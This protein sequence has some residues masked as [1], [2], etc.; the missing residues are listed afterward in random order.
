MPETNYHDAA[1]CEDI[2]DDK[3]SAQTWASSLVSGALSSSEESACNALGTKYETLSSKLAGGGS[4]YQGRVE[5]E[6]L[7]TMSSMKSGCT[8]S[9][10][11]ASIIALNAVIATPDCVKSSRT[12]SCEVMAKHHQQ[13]ASSAAA[14]TGCADVAKKARE[15]ASTFAGGV[16]THNFLQWPH[17]HYMYEVYVKGSD[18]TD[19]ASC[20]AASKGALD[21][22]LNHFIKSK[23]CGL[24]KGLGDPHITNVKGVQF[25]IQQTGTMN[26]LQIPKGQADSLLKVD[27]KVERV[28]QC[29]D[30]YIR[31]LSMSGSKLSTEYE[32]SVNPADDANAPRFFFR[33]GNFTTGNPTEFYA[34]MEKR[35]D[36]LR[37]EMAPRGDHWPIKTKVQMEIQAGKAVLS[38]NCNM[39]AGRKND[40]FDF[41]ADKIGYLGANA[42]IGGLLG[43]EDHT[44]VTKKTCVEPARSLY[45][46]DEAK[47]STASTMSASASL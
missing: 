8:T 12:K 29:K 6:G 10:V 26:F 44:W 19:A 20:T 1:Q 27:G 14:S 13:L 5:V 45:K 39:N 40:H 9:N 36:V 35:A 43:S 7:S 3:A 15:D 17:D 41:R 38:V 22:Q 2:Y 34:H 32:F 37:M 16:A 33:A 4:D 28:G 46:A 30:M 31:Q 42:D 25:D 23:S 24:A 21:N 18:I 11:A 47:V